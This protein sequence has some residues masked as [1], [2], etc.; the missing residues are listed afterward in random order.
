MAWLLLLVSVAV[1]FVA[2]AKLR[3]GGMPAGRES[4]PASGECCGMH[5]VC[6]KNILN[7]DPAA[8]ADYYDDEELDRFRGREASSYSACEVDEFRDILYTMPA[9]DVVGW[10][11]S[12]QVRGVMLPSLLVDEV[13]LIVG[14][15][16]FKE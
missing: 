16:R 11:R 15:N 10:C 1:A 8:A 13:L 5:A 14:E 6:S 3:K 12:L 2:V 4:E 9:A 7:Q